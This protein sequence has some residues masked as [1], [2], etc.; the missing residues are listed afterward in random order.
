[1]TS[2]SWRTSRGQ[3]LNP[4]EQKDRGSCT[5]RENTSFFFRYY[6]VAI[7]RYV[8]PLGR[9]VPVEFQLK[10]PEGRDNLG[11]EE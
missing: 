9:S 1:M 4:R 6:E 2:I 10:T 7:M 3:Y 8:T 11:D 5:V